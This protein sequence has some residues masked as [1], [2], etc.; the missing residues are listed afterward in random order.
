MSIFLETYISVLIINA[1]PYCREKV[2][3]GPQY[4]GATHVTVAQAIENISDSMKY[5]SVTEEVKNI[6]IV[7]ISIY[8]SI[9]VE[10]LVASCNGN[11][12]DVNRSWDL[13][14]VGWSSSRPAMLLLG[15]EKNEVC[16]IVFL[17]HSHCVCLHRFSKS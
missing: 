4:R 13:V 14:L 11:G 10:I 2:L 9:W 12:F 3:A 17:I 1:E 5:F 15:Y 7:I 8:I 6:R 16:K